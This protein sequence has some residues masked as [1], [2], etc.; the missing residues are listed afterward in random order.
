MR[1]LHCCCLAFLIF[2]AC[3]SETSTDNLL[4]DRP[5]AGQELPL[6]E[7]N[8][9][10]DTLL[11]HETFDLQDGTFIMSARHVDDTFEGLRLYHYRI[12]EQGGMTVLSYSSP[13][14][15]SWMMRPNFFPDPSGGFIIL[16]EFGYIDS[17][18]QKVLSLDE[19]G[20][21]D[22]GFLEVAYMPD[23]RESSDTT[24]L[25]VKSIAPY[26]QIAFKQ[27]EL[28]IRFTSDEVFLYDDGLGH[29]DTLYNADDVHYRLQK[30]TMELIIERSE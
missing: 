15:D 25:G 27:D 20:F 11:V 12:D 6:I 30:G 9:S 5:Q 29:L 8:V 17:W 14:Y 13:A 1:F 2:A 22:L 4:P 19:N 21:S 3:S 28:E 18:G 10:H 16:A 26:A 24:N 7:E 23:E